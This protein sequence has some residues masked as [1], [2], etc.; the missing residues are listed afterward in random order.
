MY[1]FM[2][3]KVAMIIIV[4]KKEEENIDANTYEFRVVRKPLARWRHSNQLNCS[5]WNYA[6]QH[7]CCLQKRPGLLNLANSLKLATNFE[8]V[9]RKRR[10]NLILR[11]PFLCMIE[12]YQ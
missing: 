6:D 9:P 8:M 7:R 10:S 5:R 3:K 11:Q 1:T 4:I 2:V 12:L